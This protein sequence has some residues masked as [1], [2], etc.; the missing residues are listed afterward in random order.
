M[1][2]EREQL[3]GKMDKVSGSFAETQGKAKQVIGDVRERSGSVM[4]DMD[5]SPWP[6]LGGALLAFTMAG[7]AV[8]FAL[9]PSFRTRLGIGTRRKSWPER[10]IDGV[11]DSGRATLS[12][13]NLK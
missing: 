8:W 5:G 2:G 12:A 7:V 10:F 4:S 6:R 9:V 11:R 1:Q 13:L 3:R